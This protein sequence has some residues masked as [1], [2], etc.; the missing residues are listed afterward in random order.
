MI[1]KSHSG[2]TFVT[3]E[4]MSYTRIKQDNNGFIV[5][6]KYT[7]HYRG[8]FWKFRKGGEVNSSLPDLHYSLLSLAQ[9]VL[10]RI[11][12]LKRFLGL[13]TVSD[14]VIRTPAIETAISA[15]SLLK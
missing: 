14:E 6:R 10:I 9:I 1:V 12:P 3:N 15:A 2:N 11:L 5:D 4:A 7:R 13:R 8:S